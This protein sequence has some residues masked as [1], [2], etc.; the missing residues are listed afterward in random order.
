MRVASYNI[1]SC[2]GRDGRADPDR[3][4]AVLD[5]LDAQVIGLQEV[6][7][8]RRRVPDLDGFGFFERLEGWHF[9][10]GV[11]IAYGAGR[12][13]NGL[14]SRTRPTAA[15]VH[16]LPAGGMEPR[17]LIE[18]EIQGVRFLITHLSLAPRVRRA[19]IGVI[20]G[21]MEKG[22]TVA[23]GDFN[24]WN[25]FSRRLRPLGA[26]SAPK[27]GAT[28]PA[29]RPLFRLDRLFGVDSA[30]VHV[31]PLARIASDHLPVVGEVSDDRPAGAQRAGA[32]T[33]SK[34]R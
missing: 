26:H 3:V 8:F 23:L 5:E 9:V 6:E 20:A 30:R 7:S 22:R 17:C 25:P 14:L 15:S 1:H 29:R 33:R 21:R 11:A 2:R 13:G 31:S 18:A 27:T 10:P 24:E 34:L 28:W 12:Y 19:Q 4:A 32:G 16:L